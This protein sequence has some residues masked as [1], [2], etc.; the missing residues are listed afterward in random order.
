MS[1]DLEAAVVAGATHLRVGRSVLGER[2]STR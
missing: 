2:A 1:G